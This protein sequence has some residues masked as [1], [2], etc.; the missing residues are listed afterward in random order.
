MWSV[1]NSTRTHRAA[2]PLMWPTNYTPLDYREDG[3]VHKIQLDGGRFIPV[4]FS[5]LCWAALPAE[6]P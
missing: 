2:G 5:L 6:A 3:S 4:C 1:M